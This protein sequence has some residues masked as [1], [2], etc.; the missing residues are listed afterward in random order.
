MVWADNPWDAK[1]PAIAE[2]WR[3]NTAQAK[4]VGVVYHAVV[5]AGGRKR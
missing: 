2:L 4:P 5:A 3:A 1:I